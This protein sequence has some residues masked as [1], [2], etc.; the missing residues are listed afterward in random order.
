MEEIHSLQEKLDD[1]VECDDL[2]DVLT[3]SN[4]IDTL[5]KVNL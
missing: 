5:I 2:Q 3:I 1:V 4:E